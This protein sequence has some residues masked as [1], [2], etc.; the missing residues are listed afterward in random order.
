MNVKFQK[1]RLS[2]VFLATSSSF[3]KFRIEI[4]VEIIDVNFRSIFEIAFILV[5]FSRGHLL[6]YIFS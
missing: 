1:F 5:V 3:L 4:D 6:R 2:S